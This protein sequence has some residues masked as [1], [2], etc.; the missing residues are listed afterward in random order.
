MAR[1]KVT[2]E[3]FGARFSCSP[4]SRQAKRF[5]AEW[6]ADALEEAGCEDAAILGHCRGIERCPDCFH[7]DE[8]IRIYCETCGKNGGAGKMGWIRLRGPHVRGCWVCDIL[9]GRE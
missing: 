2:L 4:D 8:C 1:S 9:T 5:A 7:A 6:L 3:D